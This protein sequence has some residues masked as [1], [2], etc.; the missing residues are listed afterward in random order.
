V[1]RLQTRRE[2]RH[3]AGV[4][5][6][7]GTR[8]AEEALAAGVTARLVLHTPDPEPRAAAIVQAFSERG[9]EV[10]A[11]TPRIL[12][13]CSDHVTP[14]GLLI[15]VDRP[16]LPIPASL[17]L[18]LVADGLADPGNLGSLMRT[19]VAAGVEAMFL[20][21]GSVDP[22]NPKVVRGGM[23]AHFRLPIET[24][25]DGPAS[26]S[27]S[28]LEIWLAAAWD[29]TVYHQV[30]WRKPTALVVGGEARGGDPAWRARASG[31]ARIPMR[32]GIDSLNAA[33]AAGVILFEVARQRGSP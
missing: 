21:P 1:R 11:V 31:V 29:G 14:P 16:K 17:S 2:A 12:E 6:L 27:L 18:A 4:F 15:V 19:C 32:P 5:V 25:A 30:D 3:E 8:S 28:G 13:A 22:Y 33:V 23:G 24:L 9:S 20:M 26:P 7:E 10:L